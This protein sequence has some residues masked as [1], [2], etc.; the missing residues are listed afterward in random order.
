[1]IGVLIFGADYHFAIHHD[2]KPIAD[3]CL[4]KIAKFFLP[5]RIEAQ[6]YFPSVLFIPS[7]PR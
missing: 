2:R 6:D 7:R 5:R 3:I 1:M 4:G